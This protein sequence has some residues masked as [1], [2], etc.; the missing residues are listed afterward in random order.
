MNGL[1][2]ILILLL[3]CYS[4]V[5]TAQ[6]ITVDDTRTAQQLIQNVLVN[7]SCANVSSF[8]ARGNNAIPVENSYAYFNSGGS[9]FPFSEGVLLST[10]PSKNAIGPYVSNRGGGGSAWLGDADLDQTLGINSVNATVLEFDF[11]PLTNYISFNYVFASNE[12]QSYFPC[13]FS[14]GF[15][16]LIKEKGSVSNYKN[17]AV[18]PGTTTPVSSENVHSITNTV[19]DANGISHP[20]CPA[21]NESYFNGFN[22]AASPINYSGQ[23]IKLNAQTDVIAGK[24]YHIKLVIAD[25]KEEYYDS[26]VF[27]EAGSFAAKIDLGPDRSSTTSNPLCFGQSFTIDTKLLASYKY[28]WYKN[29]IL[30]S[31][32]TNPSYT[33]TE[34]GTYKVKVTLSPSTCS[35]EDEI[36]IEYTPQIIL[37]NTVLAQCDDDGDGISIFDL[38]KADPIIRNNDPKLVK[39]VYFNSLAEAQAEMNPISNPSTYRNTAPNQV[40]Y[41]RVANAFGCVDYATLKLI[42]SNNSIAT[43]T[44]IESCD[45]DALQDGLTQFNLNAK[46]TPQVINGLTTGLT[47]EY[48]LNQTDA[49]AQKNQLPNLFTNTIPNQ[50]II[51]ARI[52]NGA[53]CFRITPETL[54]IHTFDPSN[55]QDETFILCNGSNT[56]LTV[57]SGFSSYL[58]SNGSTANTTNISTPGEY[59]VTVSNT[60]GC[61]KTKKFIIKASG[62]GLITNATVT[63]FSGT[64]NSVLISYSGDGDYEFSLDDNFY[65]DN[66]LFT[67]VNAGIYSATVRDKNGCGISI[68]YKVYVLD[69][70]RFFTPNNDGYNDTWKIKNLDLLPKSTIAILDRYG[71]LLQQFS[72]NSI[73][74]SGTYNGKELPADDYWFIIT[75]EDEKIIK[76]H[77]SLKR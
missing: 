50:Q 18:L 14:D 77:F 56:N 45:L 33:V 35:A 51:Y 55:F 42:I 31:S 70:P 20:G 38:T 17:I 15:A 13:A 52:V 22:T 61:K 8:N 74:W 1:K 76:G 36:K 16:F 57:A 58:W 54:V 49:I 60:N 68:P 75:F 7:S 34:A 71:K 37:S 43:Q 24:T 64:E 4:T 48:Y 26:A 39:V 41:A 69:Y 40:L 21:I 47:V 27:L 32:A 65:Q 5:A 59:T 28:E 44:P 30:I 9:N 67:G 46:I 72:S 25:D 29:G 23:T 3:Y 10:S 73:G 63:D 19:V 11:V 62:I 2:N 12:Y 53:D 66:P 6:Y